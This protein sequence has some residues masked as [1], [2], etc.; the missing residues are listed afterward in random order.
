MT[1]T[2]DPVDLDAG[3]EFELVARNRRADGHTDEVGVHPEVL[4]R[5]LE[6]LTTLFHGAGVER[7]CGAA[8]QQVTGRQCPV[9]VSVAREVDRHL[10]LGVLV[11]GHHNRLLPRRDLDFVRGVDDELRDKRLYFVFF[12]LFVLCLERFVLVLFAVC[13][14]LDE[15]ELRLLIHDRLDGLAS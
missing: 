10:T 4:E 15:V 12:V 9:S 11:D 1:Q 7:L 13:F 3:R 14:C 2:G 8:L 5:G 6:H